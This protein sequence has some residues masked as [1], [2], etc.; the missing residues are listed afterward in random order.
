MIALIDAY[1]EVE[2]KFGDAVTKEDHESLV[3]MTKELYAPFINRV[4]ACTAKV[5]QKKQAEEQ[6]NKDELEAM[7]K[8]ALMSKDVLKEQLQA[9]RE[10]R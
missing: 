7:I 9:E 2:G 5:G 8:E 1:M 3:K 4:T 6:K 10:Y